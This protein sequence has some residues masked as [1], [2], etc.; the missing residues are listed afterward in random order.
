[1]TT[2][3]GILRVNSSGSTIAN[4][5]SGN[6]NGLLNGRPSTFD[7]DAQGNLWVVLSG[8]LYKLPLANSGNI[9]KYSFNADLSS[10]ASI[11]VLSLSTSDTDILLAKTSGNAAI[12]IR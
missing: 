3:T 8:E 9:K 5:N 2:G 11:S 12:K 1:M 6:T 7:F 10:L 4:Y